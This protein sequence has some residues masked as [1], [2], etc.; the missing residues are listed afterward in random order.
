MFYTKKIVGYLNYQTK[1]MRTLFIT[2]LFLC[3]GMLTSSAQEDET[4]TLTIEVSVTKYNKGKVLL[5]LYNSEDSY[6]E[7]DYKSASVL[8]ENNKAI[9]TFNDIETGTYAFSLFH[10]VND[11]GKLDTNFL[12]IPKEPYGFSNNEKGRFGPPKYKD[13]EFIVAQNKT[14]T[15]KI[16]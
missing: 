3:S 8:V 10:D 15:L 4:V 1:T 2:L 12:G 6:M 7:D 11:N 16:K 5:A 9:I 13:V 14:I